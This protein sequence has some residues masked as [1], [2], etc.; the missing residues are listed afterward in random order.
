MGDGS[1]G[2]EFESGVD[3]TEKELDLISEDGF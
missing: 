3:A 2:R 1:W